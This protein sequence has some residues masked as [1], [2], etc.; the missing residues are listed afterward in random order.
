M[1]LRCTFSFPAAYKPL[2]QITFWRN[3][4]M[5][6][7]IIVALVAVLT[8]GLITAGVSAFSIE[9]DFEGNTEVFQALK[10]GDYEA[11]M[12]AM[13]EDT[14][15]EFRKVEKQFHKPRHRLNPEI[16][17]AL[18]S[19]DYDTFVETLEG[20]EKI[21]KIFD[22]VTE[23]NFDT[24]VALHQAMQDHDRETAKALADE[25]GLEKPKFLRHRYAPDSM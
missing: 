15:N 10:D 9:E 6:K 13:D 3:S 8:L 5:K 21:P 23:E 14:F 22:G 17:E 19:E 16:L 4:K 18:D 25:L 2:Q 24:Y 12:D 11:F 20:L 1:D 7:G